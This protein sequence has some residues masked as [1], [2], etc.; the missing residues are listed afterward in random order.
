M[1]QR[2]V[3]CLALHVTADTVRVSYNAG[4]YYIEFL[5]EGA[6][7]AAIPAPRDLSEEDLTAKVDKV[8][9]KAEFLYF[10][11]RQEWMKKLLVAQRVAEASAFLACVN[12]LKR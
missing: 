5:Y 7:T 10:T 12:R 9:S 1:F 2:N 6:R 4:T 11:D 8:L 3:E